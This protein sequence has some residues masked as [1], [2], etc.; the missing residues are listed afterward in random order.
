MS[1]CL[2]VQPTTWSTHN[3]HVLWAAVDELKEDSPEPARPR[4]HSKS[5]VSNEDGGRHIAR[6]SLHQHTLQIDLPFILD[7]GS[8][9]G[10]N[11]PSSNHTA[12][13]LLETSALQEHM[14]PG[15][16]RN[17]PQYAPAGASS[18]QLQSTPSLDRAP[19]QPLAVSLRQHSSAR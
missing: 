18:S 19:D 8:S 6:T 4:V 7:A 11:F 17:M 12:H 2:F 10:E 5:L 1:L 3:K 9:N 16:L 13:V 14:E 15:V